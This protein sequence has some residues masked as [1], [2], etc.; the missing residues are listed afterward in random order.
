MPELSASVG[1]NRVDR[2]RLRDNVDHVMSAA[3]G[4]IHVGH[5]ERLSHHHVVD[6]NAEETTEAVLV[7]VSG[8]E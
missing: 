2:I 5:I 1:V 8:S 7:D 6:G 3:T 4:D